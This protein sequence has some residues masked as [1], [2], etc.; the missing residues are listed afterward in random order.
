MILGDICTRDCTF[1][2]VEKGKPSAPDTKEP[3]HVVE[4][5][6]K[7]GLRY[8][9]ITSVTRDD[10][11]DGGSSHFA[12]TIKAINSYNADILVE[13]LIPDFKGSIPALQT[14]VDASPAVINHNIETVP[15]LYPEVRPRAIYERSLELLNQTKLLDSRLLTKSGFM[16]GLGESQQ[17]VVEVMNDLRQTG[18]DFLTIGQYLQ[19]SLKHHRIVRYV[20][21]EEFEEYENLGREMGFISVISGPLVRS[22]FHASGMYISAVLKN[23]EA[24]FHV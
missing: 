2:S 18:C 5:V 4:A 7:L 10:L 6:N 20:P 15:R 17:E 24:V 11:A 23:K 16:L 12:Q 21:N 8:V 14:V 13:A 9:V 19:P 22:S 1:C 3:E